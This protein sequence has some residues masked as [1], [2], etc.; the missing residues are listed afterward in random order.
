MVAITLTSCEKE[1]TGTGSTGGGG[2][3]PEG[4]VDLGL[5]SGTKWKAT[6]E[7][8]YYGYDSAMET[9]GSQL[10]TKEQFEELIS[11]CTYTWDA[12]RKGANFTSTVNS[13]S[14]FMP[15]AGF[16]TYVGVSSVGS[17]GC[18]WS[19]TPYG[20]DNA[21]SLDFASGGMGFG[22]YD[23]P[24]YERSVRLVKKQVAVCEK[25]HK[26]SAEF[27]SALFIYIAST[28]TARLCN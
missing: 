27:S 4:Y 26:K 13:K 12:D 8:G 25:K 28:L 15:A 3:T 11:L 20:S 7:G 18:Y 17:R 24:Y 1:S 6:N 21:L 2:T 22:N 10:P 23:Y 14:I 16:R 5:P 19:S 9:F